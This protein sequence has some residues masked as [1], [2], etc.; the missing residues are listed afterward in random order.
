M[1]MTARL[2]SRPTRVQGDVLTS[3]VR[4]LRYAA[5]RGQCR[6]TVASPGAGTAERRLSTAS[7]L[8]GPAP[9]AEK[10]SQTKQNMTAGSPPFITGQKPRGACPMKYA[11]AIWPDRRN[12]TGRVKS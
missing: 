8:H 9:A 7:R 1:Q 4:P 2:K 5:D 10:Y 12:A 3:P 11:N 6:A